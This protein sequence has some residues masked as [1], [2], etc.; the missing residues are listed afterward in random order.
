MRPRLGRG[1]GFVERSG[2]VGVEIV[3]HQHDFGRAGKMHIGQVPERVGVVD[4]GVAVCHFHPGLRRGR[5][6]R[7]PS[8]G[9]KIITG[10]ATP[11][12]AYS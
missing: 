8:S 5:L 11:L 4:G 2:L 7:Q 6:C 9:A 10:L 3:L 1:K 12:R